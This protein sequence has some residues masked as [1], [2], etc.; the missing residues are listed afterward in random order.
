MIIPAKKLTLLTLR[1]QERI[2]L[3]KLGELG[4]I[5]LRRLSDED[6]RR[7]REAESSKLRELENLSEKLIKLWQDL[8]RLGGERREDYQRYVELREKLNELY[9]RRAE[10]KNLKK[11]LEAAASF[12]EEVPPAGRLNDLFSLLI[13][14]PKGEFEKLEKALS[15]EKLAIRSARASDEEILVNIVGLS[16]HLEKVHA[17]LAT[18][19][20]QEISLPQNLPRRCRD[21]IMAI[22]SDLEKIESEIR[23]IE[24]EFG[25]LKESIMGFSR[26]QRSSAPM[27]AKLRHEALRLLEELSPGEVKV[28]EELS[29]EEASK[30]LENL[31]AGY[32]SIKGELDE[33]RR[34]RERLNTLKSLLEKLVLK[35]IRSIE[36]GEYE[37]ITVISGLIKADRLEELRR[38]LLK[39]PIALKEIELDNGRAFLTI[40]CLREDARE[41]L[42]QL[43]S[44]EFEDLTQLLQALPRDPS[45]ALK[46]INEELES[47][48][49]REEELVSRLGDFRKSS[50]PKIVA[51]ARSLEL[52]LKIDEAL[53][54]TLR[55]EDLR[56]I[57]GWVPADKIEEF[58]GELE[59]LRRRLGKS[60]AYHFEDPSPDEDVPTVLKNPKLFKV[61]EGLVAQ[62]GWPGHREIDPTIISGILWTM[63]FGLMFPDSG[64]GLAIIGIGAFLA[65]FFKGKRVLG[66][67]AKKLGKLMIGLGISA[68]IFGL[69]FGEF[70][71]TE[72]HPLVPGLRPG[73]LEDPS[74]TVWLLKIAVF[75][76]IAQIILAMSLAAWNELRNGEIIDAVL[77]HHGLA[78]IIA[79]IGFILTAFHFLGISVIPG[80]LEFPEL[81]MDSLKAW[82]F[83]LMLAGFVM[84][85]LKPVVAK[86]SIS[87]GLGNIL[88]VAIAFLANTFSYARIAGFAIV[89]AALAMVV[90]RMMHANPLMGIGM[91]LIFLNLFTL[92]IELLVCMIQALRLLYYEFYSKFY[93]GMGIPYRPWKIP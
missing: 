56:V 31:I 66:V 49:A 82:P 93:K 18:V 19:Y 28:R 65:Y 64:Q 48:R 69:L 20:H 52:N 12:G 7:F 25:R 34:E 91:G 50:L 10:L 36:A 86:E 59:E 87:L 89:H 5:H 88:E 16:D 58:A 45:E 43:K 77:S 47:L 72:T 3:R 42:E 54:N 22:K 6:A 1:D 81:G 51:I 73:W 30:L 79:F 2:V 71:L 90:H 92:S 84:M 53:M 55:S 70:F 26:E 27:L 80:V 37:N 39:K 24:E 60:F 78:G 38:I 76:G 11:V 57:Q 68:T 62:Y 61:F 17:A 41:I 13:I 8:A 14:V 23:S 85:A 40:A 67:N 63:M 35:K 9:A 46:K 83:Y 21:A 15:G 4:V 33:L 44:L 32:R 74:G 29:V 75:F